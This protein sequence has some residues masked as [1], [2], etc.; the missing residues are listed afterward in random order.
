M[1][2]KIMSVMFLLCL[3]FQSLADVAVKDLYNSLENKK[4]DKPYTQFIEPLSKIIG[5]TEP[6]PKSLDS[7]DFIEQ[8]TGLKLLR[9]YETP[10]IEQ[11]RK[12]VQSDF[13]TDGYSNKA[14]E[15]FVVSFFV[16]NHKV[17][18]ILLNVQ[19]RY[20]DQYYLTVGRG[21][22]LFCVPIT[23]DEAI[24]NM[25]YFKKKMNDSGW[26]L[27]NSIGSFFSGNYAFTKGDIELVVRNGTFYPLEI[28]IKRK[29]LTAA[30]DVFDD[31]TT[32]DREMLSQSVEENRKKRY[33]D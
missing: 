32:L 26:V 27:T 10:I 18:K 3:S 1:F 7:I 6:L 24:D 13:K 9:F 11:E 22:C 16:V 23:P 28:D 33:E 5:T 31:L 30:R 21:S 20:E 8:V 14:A 15:N 2:K 25:T 17:E 19:S 29:D 4:F 12:I